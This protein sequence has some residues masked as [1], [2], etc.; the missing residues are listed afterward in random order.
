MRMEITAWKLAEMVQG[1][2]EGD[3][4][5]I[6]K[7]PNKIEI[8]QEGDIT[9]L[10]NLKYETY[11]YTTQASVLLV[12]KD[13]V[14]KQKINATLIRVG[15]V[16]ATVALLLDKF[17]AKADVSKGI[18]TIS[19]IH[20]DSQIDSSV[21]I[22]D[23][24][25]IEKGVVIGADTTI[26]PQV[27]IGQNARIGKGCIIYPGVKIYDHSVI[28][29]NCI[30]HSNTV[31]G[32][33][34]FGFVPQADGTYKKMAQTGNVVIESQVEIGSNCCIDRATMGTTVIRKGAKLDNLI[35][36]AHNV[37][38]GENTVVAAQ[39]GFAGSTKVGKSC[40]IG[41]QTGFVG[42]IQIANGTKIQ[43]QSGINKSIVEE[44]TAWYGS[45]ALSYNDYLKSYAA[46]KKL[47][48]LMKR[49]RMLEKEI[50]EK[51]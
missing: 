21:N 17:G 26:Y 33:D 14:P 23:Y 37:E 12:S 49:L 13:F 19:S 28:G 3:A 16:Y 18:S 51:S 2:V 32:A 27:F 22:G 34:G 35:M 48:D 9:F 47:P 25:V 11:A 46:F 42:H 24:T 5:V 6:I 29:D 4:N 7:K 1:E 50:S 8:A 15:D 31:I 30:I 45:P 44:N 38:I 20:S 43:A 40:M 10:A 39:A 41:G 36:V